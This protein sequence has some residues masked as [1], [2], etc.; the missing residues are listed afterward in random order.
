[1][2]P[3]VA[4]VV[5]RC[6]LEVNGGAEALCRM[7]AERLATH[8]PTEVLT[9]CALDYMTWANHYPP[10]E[11]RIGDLVIRRFPVARPRDVEAF[12]RFSA[13][14]QPRVRSATIAEQEEWM[15]QQG[16]WS[17]SL[18]QYLREKKDVYDA[19]IFVTYL[20]A[21]TY[22]GLPCVGDKALLVPLA[23]DEWP[24]YFSMWDGFFNLPR[25][26]I[27]SSEEEAAFVRSRFAGSNLTGPI[28]GVAVDPPSSIDPLRFRAK[29]EVHEPFVSYIGRVDVAKGVD[30]LVADFS[31]YRG[32]SNDRQT[33][34]VLIGKGAIEM[35]A[36]GSEIR[37]V[38]FLPEQ[39]KWEAIAGSELLVMPSS[40]ESLSI[41]LLE[42][43]SVG[44]PALVSARSPVL[45]G[46]CRRAQGGLWYRDTDEF[47]VALEYLLRD[48]RLRQKLGDQGRAFVDAHYRWSRIVDGYRELI[49][50]VA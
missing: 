31:R 32:E 47:C 7:V 16:P 14:L 12:N 41:A 37:A 10:G 25:R 35:P 15:R 21:T 50:F 3:R 18:L 45:V 38:G 28:L 49:S 34:L 30:Q 19:F 6:G 36:G 17:P 20:Y 11:E 27:F 1:M 13:S 22:F 33:G 5:Q 42:A 29:Y 48:D 2:N 24:I 43:W 23:H 44:K 40:F 8:F 4:F 9:T 26:L 46:Q 39:E